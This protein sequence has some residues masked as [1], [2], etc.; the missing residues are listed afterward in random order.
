MIN[1]NHGHGYNLGFW[2]CRRGLVTEEKEPSYKMN[3]IKL[4]MKSRNLHLFCLIES[5]LHGF[6][7]RYKRKHPLT[8]KDILT[9]LHIPGYKIYLP[10]TWYKH[11]QARLIVY[12]KE[13]LHVS[14]M[15]LSES[16]TDLPV[17]TFLVSAGKEKKTVVSFFY[18][19]FTGGVAGLDDVSSQNERLKRLTN[20]W[21]QL[22]R[23]NRDLICLGDANLCAKN[24]MTKITNTVNRQTS[25]KAFY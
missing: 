21:R 6:V 3:E 20:Y 25:Y 4:F 2:N 19:E 18:R 10:K 7:S 23:S 9:I 16:L 14:E 15:T 12:A 11:G 24:G 17:M 1:G 13:E 8:E 5:D 22:S